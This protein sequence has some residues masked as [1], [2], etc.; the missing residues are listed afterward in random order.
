M[1]QFIVHFEEGTS[2]GPFNIYLSGSSGETLYAAGVT[3]AQ[4]EAGFVVLFDDS[5]PS[6]SIVVV[7]ESYGCGNEVDLPFPTLTP[8]FT[9]STTITPSI[10]P[11]RFTTPSVTRT[12]TPTVTKTPSR[13]VSRTVTVSVSPSYNP[14]ASLSVTPTVT[15]TRTPSI[16]P[17]R[18]VTPQPPNLFLEVSQSGTPANPSWEVQYTNLNNPIYVANV[19]TLA[20]VVIPGGYSGINGVYS[21]NPLAVT[22]LT[23]IQIKLRKLT[24][25]GNTANPTGLSLYI[26]SG[27]GFGYPIDGGE[28]PVGNYASYIDITS[29][30]S[31]TDVSVGY[32]M[33]LSIIEG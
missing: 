13:T 17:T 3:K 1:P 6:S 5:I 26:D 28:L 19:T 25:S 9:P 18:T 10:T 29:Y 12:I 15:V 8:S 20:N 2:P 27:M 7:N 23:P 32:K 4:L 30:F 33:K 14:A 24:N 16:T 21:N 31:T 22:G 11:T